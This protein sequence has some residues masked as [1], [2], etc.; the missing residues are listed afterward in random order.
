VTWHSSEHSELAIDVGVVSDEPSWDA[1]MFVTSFTLWCGREDD[2][3]GPVEGVSYE[4][5][6]LRKD[7]FL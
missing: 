6:S 1:F 3:D 5:W 7:S 2:F 4:S